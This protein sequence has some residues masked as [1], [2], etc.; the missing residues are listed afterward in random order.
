VIAL[1]RQA[2]TTPGGSGAL[3]LRKRACP[4]SV[5]V[6]VAVNDLASS[7]RP[8]LPAVSK[9]NQVTSACLSFGIINHSLVDWDVGVKGEAITGQVKFRNGALDEDEFSTSRSVLGVSYGH[10]GKACAE[11]Q[12]KISD[13][14]NVTNRPE[15]IDCDIEFDAPNRK[16]VATSFSLRLDP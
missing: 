13:N 14:C 16:P 1:W 4:F 3:V 11:L 12:V 5:D 10:H 6:I 15:S 2:A 8:V 9:I 7:V